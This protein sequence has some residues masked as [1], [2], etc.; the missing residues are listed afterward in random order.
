MSH[1]DVTLK[2]SIDTITTFSGF[3]VDILHVGVVSNGLPEHIALVVA[4]VYAMNV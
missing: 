2:G 1:P 4:Q 3:Q